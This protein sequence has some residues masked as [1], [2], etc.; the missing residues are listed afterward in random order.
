MS[1]VT[2]PTCPC[3]LFAR[4]TEWAALAGARWLGRDDEVDDRLS[5]HPDQPEVR[6]DAV[7]ELALNLRAAADDVVVEERTGGADA[8]AHWPISGP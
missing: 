3:A 2:L 5:E 8:R 1:D 6:R 7:L 4:A